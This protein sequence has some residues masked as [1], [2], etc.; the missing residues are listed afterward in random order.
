MEY[1]EEIIELLKEYIDIK[2]NDKKKYEELFTKKTVPEKVIIAQKSLDLT[3]GKTEKLDVEV[4]PKNAKNKDVIYSSTNSNI[5][6]ISD[7]G[8]V[9][10]MQVGTAYVQAMSLEDN[11]VK[12]Y[13]KVTVK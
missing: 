2:K 8:V 1:K 7:D 11:A 3:V 6:S 5:V 13:I 10:A 12:A 9:T 4:L